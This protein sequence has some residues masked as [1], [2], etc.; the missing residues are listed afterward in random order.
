M[1][2]AIGFWRTG[3]G[4]R[5][6]VRGLRARGVVR[7]HVAVSSKKNLSPVTILRTRRGERRGSVT[8]AGDCG[9][10]KTVTGD[11]AG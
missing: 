10:E 9:V 7:I 11:C 5:V 1:V 8:I 3:I 4:K 2:E 6:T